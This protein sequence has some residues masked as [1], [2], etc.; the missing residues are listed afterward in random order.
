TPRS[1]HTH[2][3]GPTISSSPR[4]QSVMAPT[5]AQV[6]SSGGMCLPE[7]WRCRGARNA[8]SKAGWTGNDRAPLRRRPHNVHSPSKSNETATILETRNHEPEVRHAEEE[9]DALL[10]EITS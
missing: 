6:A 4:S 9:P 2:A 3:P 7:R 10:G 5:A 8:T 1:D